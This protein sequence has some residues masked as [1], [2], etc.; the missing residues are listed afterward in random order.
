MGTRAAGE[1]FHNFFEFFQ[2]F[3]SV[4]ITPNSIEARYMFSVCLPVCLSVYE[5]HVIERNS[6]KITGHQFLSED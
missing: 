6:T 2:T 5:S 4:S 3:T 1:C